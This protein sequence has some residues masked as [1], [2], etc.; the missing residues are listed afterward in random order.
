MSKVLITGSRSWADK[1]TIATALKEIGATEIAQGGATGADC[2]AWRVAAELHIP[3]RTYQADWKKHGRG[4]GLIR[5]TE[6][7]NEF[8]PDVVLAFWD[9]SSKGTAH[10]IETSQRGGCRVIVYTQHRHCISRREMTTLSVPP[11]FGDFAI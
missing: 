6:M 4:A 7:L 3:C 9:G 8:K 2:L 5:N 1:D 10:M 11:L